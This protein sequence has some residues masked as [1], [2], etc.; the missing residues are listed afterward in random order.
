MAWQTEIDESKTWGRLR[1]NTNTITMTFASNSLR[2]SP[3]LTNTHSSP[4]GA[5]SDFLF[6]NSGRERDAFCLKALKKKKQKTFDEK[7][8]ENTLKKFV[9][10]YGAT[11][12]DLLGAASS[13]FVC[14]VSVFVF[15]QRHLQW[16]PEFVFTTKNPPA[17][18]QLASALFQCCFHFGF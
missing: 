15:G 5:G 9:L 1:T 4:P 13:E 18:L 14:I 11:G 7:K 8:D 17:P 16:I 2:L 6:S 3:I 12:V 10:S